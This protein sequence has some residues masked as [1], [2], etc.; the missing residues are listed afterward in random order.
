MGWGQSVVLWRDEVNVPAPPKRGSVTLE[1]FNFHCIIS[2]TNI[3][4]Q[5]LSD[6]V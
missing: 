1:G 2:T 6:L 5:A 3:Y 4:N